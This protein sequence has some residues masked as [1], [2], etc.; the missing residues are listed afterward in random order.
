MPIPGKNR[1]RLPKVYK[2]GIGAMTL[3]QRGVPHPEP[4]DHFV[5][6]RKTREGKSD[7]VR[8]DEAMKRLAEEQGTPKAQV[9]KVRIMFNEMANVLDSGVAWWGHR[10]TYCSARA[11]DPDVDFE[12]A[13]AP[14]D[15]N[16]E[17]YGKPAKMSDGL[18]DRIQEYHNGGGPHICKPSECPN[19]TEEPGIENKFPC[20]RYA[21][22][23]FL[24]ECAPTTP[25]VCFFYTGGWRSCTNLENSVR[26][27]FD[28]LEGLP[29]WFPLELKM[30][31]YHP[32]YRDTDGQMKTSL[33]WEVFLNYPKGAEKL[34]EESLRHIQGGMTR[35]QLADEYR[36]RKALPAFTESQ[37]EHRSTLTREFHPDAQDLPEIKPGA[38]FEDCANALGWLPGQKA[39]VLQKFGG[40][41]TEAAD[42]A[43]EEVRR[44]AQEDEDREPVELGEV[45]PEVEGES[46]AEPEAEGDVQDADWEP[47]P[48]EEAKQPEE[49][50]DF[51]AR[52]EE[53]GAPAEPE[54]ILCYVCGKPAG[55]KGIAY[56]RTEYGAWLTG[57]HDACTSCAT[58]LYNEAK[59]KDKGEAT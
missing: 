13:E 37:E 23:R 35:R 44:L 48:A 33:Q 5:I 58:K 51:K 52:A 6:Q 59:A 18:W 34:A 30:L 15:C 36:A 29:A 50:P 20:T 16:L 14:A 21:E 10:R 24:L 38:R 39:A 47:V 2:L 3:S 1:G 53:L 41:L 17:R 19:Y 40:D 57:G 49:A 28:T 55:E 56:S 46:E 54:V 22:F 4:L 31:P 45:A 42:Y 26:F 9:V 25:G 32:E 27:F 8:D 11:F 43:E 7:W 12:D